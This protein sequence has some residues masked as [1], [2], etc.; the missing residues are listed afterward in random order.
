MATR[1]GDAKM[2]TWTVTD[3]D[4]NY[5]TGKTREEAINAYVHEP[6]LVGRDSIDREA[7]IDRGEATVEAKMATRSHGTDITSDRVLMRRHK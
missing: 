4:G 5:Y 3:S 6:G 2:T 7:K 1:S